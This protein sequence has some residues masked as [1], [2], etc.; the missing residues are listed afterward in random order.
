MKNEGLAPARFADILGVPPS[1]IS[2]LLAGRNK[3]SFDFLTKMLQRFPRLNPDWLLLGTGPIYRPT[4]SATMP[5][6]TTPPTPAANPA[7]NRMDAFAVPPAG[8]Y[9]HDNAPAFDPSPG[10]R[11]ARDLFGASHEEIEEDFP[12]ITPREAGFMEEAIAFARAKS[13]SRKSAIPQ[14]ESR[15]SVDNQGIERIIICY[16]DGSFETYAN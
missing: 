12:P 11:A 10:E 4:A 3:P 5:D 13:N 15:K 8:D 7:E 14:L 16:G 9:A 2:H 6:A 1:S